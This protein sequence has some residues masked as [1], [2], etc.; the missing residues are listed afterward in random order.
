M[1]LARNVVAPAYIPNSWRWR[2]EDQ[3]KVIFG[4]IVSWRLYYVHHMRPHLT[5]DH[6]HL[7]RTL[8]PIPGTALHVRDLCRCHTPNLSTWLSVLT[9]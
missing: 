6:H 1:F 3:I 8:S 5:Q 7:Q 9:L 2:W 4:Y